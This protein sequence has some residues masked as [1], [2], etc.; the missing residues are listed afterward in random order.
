[1]AKVRKNKE[2]NLLTALDRGRQRR[3]A[4]KGAVVAIALVVVV[5]A[6]VVF[7]YLH[8]S[9]EI[10]GLEQRRDTALAY[11]QDTQSQYDES[12]TRQQEAQAAQARTDALTAAAE[13]MNSYPD[14]TG[15]DFKKLFKIAGDKVDMSGIT[16][17][18][19]TGMLTFAAKCR[20]ATRIPIFIA[21]LRLSGVFND[22][23]Y[24]GYSAGTI[25]VSGGSRT[26]EDGTVVETQDTVTEYSFN[27]TCVVNTDE[28][29]VNAE[30]ATEADSA[31]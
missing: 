9:G 26:T 30:T 7:F 18:R 29:R 3:K 23:N 20:S 31:E 17:D 21:A 8:M 1:M 11:V 16:Y 4:G 15:A 19:S 6:G 22:V 27:V 14:M 24:D 12:F 13:A 25:T 28:Q 2:L 5:A 10:D